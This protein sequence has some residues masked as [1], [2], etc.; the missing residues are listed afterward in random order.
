MQVLQPLQTEIVPHTDSSGLQEIQEC[1]LQ[2]NDEQS[3]PPGED[4]I[5][6]DPQSSDD[7]L[8]SG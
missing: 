8:V 1:Q 7:H 2:S 6:E 5:T 4:C 3:A